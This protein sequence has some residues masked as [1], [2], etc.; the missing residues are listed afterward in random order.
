MRNGYAP[1]PTHRK[2]DVTNKPDKVCS[3]GDCPNQV[4]AQGLCMKH[5]RRLL[6][7]G[8]TDRQSAVNKGQE[9][10][11]EECDRPADRQG[12]CSMHYQRQINTGDTGRVLSRYGRTLA[13]RAADLIDTSAGP[14][15]C[16]PWTGHVRKGF[17]VIA[18]GHT[19]RSARRVIAM[20]GGLVEDGSSAPLVRMRSSCEPL[21]CNIAHM[22]TAT[23]GKGTAHGG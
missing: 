23:P 18:D 21:C 2:D 15:A 10:K 1:G 5:Y 4:V 6:R 9:C 16:H 7:N 3:V 22:N 8:S 19:A 17:P 11:V 14:T 12:L 13:Q 20:S